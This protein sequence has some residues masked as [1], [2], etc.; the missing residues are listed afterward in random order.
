MTAGRRP[1]AGGI[2]RA[3]LLAAFAAG[4]VLPAT[5]PAAGASSNRSS[6]AADAVAVGAMAQPT[7]PTARPSG[8]LVPTPGPIVP[9]GNPVGKVGIVAMVV[10]AVAGLWIYRVIRKGL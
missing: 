8:N 2:F 5:L 6:V 9:R 4:F 3:V 7:T 10:V 1:R